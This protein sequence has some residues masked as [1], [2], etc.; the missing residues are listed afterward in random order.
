MNSGLTPPSFGHAVTGGALLSFHDLVSLEVV[1][2]FRDTGLSLQRLRRVEI[3]LQELLPGTSHPFA[4]RIFFT[5][6][7]DVW[8]DLGGADGAVIELVGKRAGH[9]A[10]RPAIETFAGEVRF[11]AQNEAIA[12][13]LSDRIEIDP[14]VQF[15]EPVVKGTR[16]P[17]S[18]IAREL[19]GHSPEQIADWHAVDVEDVRDVQHFLAA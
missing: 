2:R 10:W 3:A 5:N 13:D 15:G 17:I 18:V 4:H 11:G 16:L 9:Y 12:W 19:I 6:G 14:N 1:R 8:V 7:A